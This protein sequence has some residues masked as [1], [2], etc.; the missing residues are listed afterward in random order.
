MSI[1]A[2]KFRLRTCHSPDGLH[3]A[4]AVMLATAASAMAS[5]EA[6]LPDWSR[7]QQVQLAVAIAADDGEVVSDAE[8]EGMAVVGEES[9]MLSAA[10]AQH[11]RRQQ[12]N[13]QE[14]GQQQQQRQQQLQTQAQ[15]ML[16]SAQAAARSRASEQ[17]AESASQS[18]QEQSPAA[19]PQPSFPPPHHA[20]T[21]GAAA[22]P[23]TV[24]MMA[25]VPP[26]HAGNRNFIN[27]PY[28]PPKTT[29]TRGAGTV[30]GSTNAP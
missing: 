24:Q 18:S 13:Q 26:A 14:Q 15:S 8:A 30:S 12:A 25:A 22:P 21:V 5:V 23:A 28:K 4:A 19:P 27:N 29:A 1:V 11:A 17:Q 6:Q 7:R 2:E 3:P 16:D 9:A 10:V 20:E